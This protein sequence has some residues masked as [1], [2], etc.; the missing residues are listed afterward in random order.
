MSASIKTEENGENWNYHYMNV[1]PNFGARFF[2]SNRFALHAS[3][4]YQYGWG[5]SSLNGT[6]KIE[7]NYSGFAPSL[8][9]C[10]VFDVNLY[11]K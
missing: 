7:K 3:L 11:N 8:G 2:L 1:T 9:I 4:G 10:V 6:P 5:N